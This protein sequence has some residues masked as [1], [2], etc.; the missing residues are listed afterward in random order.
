MFHII[1][2]GAPGANPN[3]QWTGAGANPTAA[4]AAP[5]TAWSNNPWYVI[6]FYKYTIGTSLIQRFAQG[7]SRKCRQRMGTILR[8]LCPTTARTTTSNKRRLSEAPRSNGGSNPLP[9]VQAWMATAAG[10][11]APRYRSTSVGSNSLFRRSRADKDTSSVVLGRS[12]EWRGLFQAPLEHWSQC[13]LRSIYP[14]SNC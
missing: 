1:Y 14:V 7:R 4:G 6:S 9:T 11:K 3:P 13:I 10:S 5:V 8:L 12:R 2:S